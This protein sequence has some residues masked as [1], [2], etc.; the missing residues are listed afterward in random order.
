MRQSSAEGYE[1]SSGG[2]G[3][4]QMASGG[5]IG[6]VGNAASGT[7]SGAFGTSSQGQAGSTASLG[8]A[9]S[10]VACQVDSQCGSLLRR[11]SSGA[12]VECL[13]H[14]DCRVGSLCE[15]HACTERTACVMA[16]ECPTNLPQCDMARGFCVR[17]NSNVDCPATHICSNNLCRAELACKN[18]LDY[19]SQLVCDKAIERCVACVQDTDC[20]GANSVCRRGACVTRCTSNAECNADASH[21][22]ASGACVA[23]LSHS[24]CVETEFCD[25]G[26]CALDRCLPGESRCSG[27]N[28]E[29]CNSVGD[30][31]GAAVA[32]PGTQ[33]CV[34]RLGRATCADSPQNSGI[35]GSGP[36]GPL[37][38]SGG[39]SNV[40]TLSAGGT[41]AGATEAT[42]RGGTASGG[43]A[44][45][46][47]SG[48]VNGTSG[49]TMV[50]SGGSIDYGGTSAAAPEGGAK[51]LGGIG[52]GGGV[53][54]AANLAGALGEVG[55]YGETGVAGQ[56]GAAGSGAT[57]AG[58]ADPCT[59]FVRFVKGSQTVDGLDN[60]FC[61][62]PWFSMSF[63]SA[64]TVFEY[65]GSFGRARYP[66]RVVARVA[67]S[68]YN[69]HAFIH[70]V[71]P[72]VVAAESLDYIWGA[73]SV[74]LMISIGNNLTGS[75]AH[76]DGTLHITAAPWKTSERGMAA[77]VRTSGNS[78]THEALPAEQYFVQLTSDGY[79]VELD[80]RWPDGMIASTASRV[81]FDL[82]LNVAEEGL[83][84]EPNVRDAQA[85]YKMGRQPLGPTT[86]VDTLSPYCD[87]RLWCESHFN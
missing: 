37:A 48:Q 16:S 10:E 13:D 59:S 23:C 53:S 82:A 76:D 73:D 86:C 67:W 12:C 40:T 56:S 60:D 43:T 15:N 7:A 47:S 29:V 1:N 78:A 32:C 9:T 3:T 46:G 41:T 34:A 74:E 30:A 55:G 57:C 84:D 69:I 14:A 22:G 79:S 27:N 6:A 62:V 26:N 39:S 70:V 87:D 75:T 25:M 18:S 31:Y 61:N 64:D 65:K 72:Y 80:V 42:H 5:A 54:G 21:C 44:H 36:I 81:R 38:G 50:A 71:D 20:G 45:L 8:G 35:A 85:I 24:D 33:I 83:G 51:G 11:C 19:G 66:E 4:T 58:E 28:I 2:S 52:S 49:S 77:V 63:E 68:P 17:C